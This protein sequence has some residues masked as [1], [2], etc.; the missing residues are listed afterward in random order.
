MWLHEVACLETSDIGAIES[1]LD[2]G[3]FSIS[4]NWER[5]Q[6]GMRALPVK[7]RRIKLRPGDRRCGIRGRLDIR[8]HSKIEENPVKPREMLLAKRSHFKNIF[9]AGLRH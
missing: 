8:L 9:E 2:G 5:P 3:V 1:T 4:A 7:H 6:L